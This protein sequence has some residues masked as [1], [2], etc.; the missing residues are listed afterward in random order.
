MP[1]PK[2]K[3]LPK[4][5]GWTAEQVCAYIGM[6]V[7]WWQTGGLKL[8][9]KHGFP[10]P[11]PLTA[12]FDRA[13]VKAWYDKHSGI[14]AKNVITGGEEGWRN[15]LEALKEEQNDPPAH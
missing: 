3:Y 7:S 11:S 14:L 4:P 8:L 15:G 2:P 5:R 6:S 12:R 1:A 13:L 9:K 10:Q